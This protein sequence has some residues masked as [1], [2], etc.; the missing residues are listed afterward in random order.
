[1]ILCPCLCPCLSVSV[2]VSRSPSLSLALCLCLSL[3]VSLSVPLSHSLP[4]P[5]SRSLSSTPVAIRPPRLPSDRTQSHAPRSYTD[6]CTNTHTYTDTDTHT[7]A[8]KHC[9]VHTTYTH[10]HKQTQTHPRGLRFELLPP[11]ALSRDRPPTVLIPRDDSSSS[12]VGEISL[13]LSHPGTSAMSR[14]F[15]RWSSRSSRSWR[16]AF[17]AAILRVVSCACRVC[18]LRRWATTQLAAS[19][20]EA[21][22]AACTVCRLPASTSVHRLNS[23]YSRE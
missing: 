4:L 10:T 1:M 13:S 21:T 17:A 12:I 5:L 22:G 8:H 11:F 7:N 20:P 2:S 23:I 18:V 9:R 16:C 15:C 19:T 3:P 14:C 6:A